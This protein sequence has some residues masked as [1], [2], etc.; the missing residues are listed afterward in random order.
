M[1][2]P[3]PAAI[4][5]SLPRGGLYVKTSHGP[6]QFGMPPETIKDSMAFGLTVPT[7]YVVPHHLFHR[8]RGLN[9][10]E[11]EFPAYF[12]F[13]ILK[14]RI[15]LIVD[16]AAAEAR[17]RSVFQESLFGPLVLPQDAEFDEA[18]PREIRPDF[19]REGGHFRKGVDGKRLDVDTLV[20]FQRF[21]AH[22]RV[23]LGNGV[24]VQTQPDG[25]Y[26][27]LENGLELARAP[28]EVELP[29]RRSHL[30]PPSQ[31][32]EPPL[33]GITVL[34][35]SH[36]FDP[37]GK[38]TGFVLWVGGRGLLVDP[39]VDATELLREQGVPA[40]LIDGIILTHC[41][42]D[43]DS[44]TFQKILDEGRVNLYTTPTIL[45]SFLRKYAALSGLSEDFL[46]RT[47]THYPVKIGAPIRVHGAEISFFYTLHSIPALGFEVFYGGKSLAF[48]G[49]SLY[50]PV[51]VAALRD[52][53]V[54]SPG[55]ASSLID[56]PWHH[57]LIIHEAGVPPLHTPVGVL[58]DLPDDVKERLRV[59]HI[60]EKDVPDG[61]G[62]KVGKVGLAN[63]L[64][65]PVVPSTHAEAI[66]LLD[67]FH[68]IDLFR[69]FPLS[70]ASEILQVARRRVYPAG[71]TIIA[72]GS[73]GDTFYIITSGA[74]SVRQN[75][76]EI[77]TYQAG[78]YFGETALILG[79]P[80]LADVVA[81]TDVTLVEV[82]RYDFLYLLRETA[83]PSR[84][85]RLARMREERSW[86]IFEANSVLRALTPGQKT[87]LQSYLTTRTLQ[88]GD[89]LWY[90]GETAQE[91]FL[92]DEG[93][94]MIESTGGH[95]APFRSGGFLGEFDALRHGSALST[96]A[97][98]T[99][100][101]K[102][103]QISRDDL[104]RFFQENPGVL[105][106]FLGTKFIE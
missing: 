43:H 23:D 22:G 36:G 69:E 49:D 68:S 32:F 48:S 93:V 1:T 38:T 51:R 47:F 5:V 11:S 88:A 30:V 60:A 41:H 17:I 6:V 25:S 76:R 74:V 40:K 52:L 90:A 72:Q 66:A 84:L 18:Y 85:A 106:S 37:A 57:S 45:G 77:K 97:R 10:A 8:R 95:L 86:E 56:F 103:F 63:T 28:A 80:R 46:R 65:I 33:F 26:A 53:G 55:R 3:D 104:L 9:V 61:R 31:T 7:V 78:D 19:E 59:V 58:A 89:L 13:F 82:G 62:L 12:N 35:A 98:C 102:V 4:A 20:D 64:R 16:D 27:V 92:I 91:A 21:D 101:G 70:R 75:G 50:D 81:T 34:G 94:V 100:G 67:A 24:E 15:R 29:E 79:Q 87:Q 83:L 2:T 42:A 14:R 44:G 73:P 39:P 105:V 99:E 71:H 96:T 54:L